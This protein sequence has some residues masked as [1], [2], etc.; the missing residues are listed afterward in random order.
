MSVAVIGC[1][2][3]GKNLI[4]NFFEIGELSA[5]CDEDKLTADKFAKNYGVPSLTFDEVLRSPIK[6][7]VISAPAVYHA[8]LTI[9]ALEANKHVY[10]EK[11]LAMNIDEANMMIEKSR[12]TGLELMVGHLLQYHPV[13]KKLKEMNNNGD[14]GD[15]QYVYSNR[16]SFGKI[17][18][19]ENVIWSF[20]PHDISM[21]LSLI[22]SPVLRVDTKQT[23]IFQDDIADQA[24]IYLEFKSGVKGHVSCSW[25]NPFKEQKLV[26]VGSKCTAIFDDTLEW[27][28]KLSV[29]DQFVNQSESPPATIK[30]QVKYIEVEE[31]EPLKEEC[32]YFIDLINGKVSSLT[33][34]EEGKRVLE[35]LEATKEENWLNA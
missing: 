15:I 22:N 25:A 26:L 19:E 30:G 34:G 14:F 28:K 32:K 6:A 20:A 16:L 4:R 21:I 10:V 11:P 12:E 17:R 3:W 24:T 13:F 9:Q 31:G 35:V 2:Y 8:K 18:S 5:V 7:V 33:D 29:L 27:K 23:S 1:G